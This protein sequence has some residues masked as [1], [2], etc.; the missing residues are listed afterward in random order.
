MSN[1]VL[2]PQAHA[3]HRASD[4]P[5]EVRRALLQH[6]AAANVILPFVKKVSKSPGDDEHLWIALYDEKHNVEFVLSCTKGP[7]GDYPIFIV[8]CKSSA[9]LADDE[10]R[11]KDLAD[12]LSPLVLCLLENVPPKR[13]FSVFSIAKVAEKFAEIFVAQ[14]HQEHGV[15]AH[16]DPY[17]DATFT[18]CTR[19]TLNESQ[20]LTFPLRESEDIV[21]ALR[22]AD[23]SHLNGIKTMCKDFAE[24]SVGTVDVVR[25]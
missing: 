10:M 16:E 1:D 22:R 17:Y 23:M 19:E 24:T 6:E 25:I 4:L 2:A 9:Q 8:A 7:L 5:E 13:V 18:F 12:S 15:Q 14:T 20:D 3:Y 21:V 11:G